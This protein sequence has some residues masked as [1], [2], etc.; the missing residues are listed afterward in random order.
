ML[1]T[2]STKEATIRSL[3]AY[4]SVSPQTMARPAGLSRESKEKLKWLSTVV[5][6]TVIA[7]GLVYRYA[8]I[9]QIN[10]Q[11]QQLKLQV[12]QQQD[13]IAKLS[14]TKQNLESPARILQI[15]QNK[16]GMV[17]LDT[18]S[19]SQGNQGGE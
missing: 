10:L 15:A 13:E 14:K 6:C 16:L 11:V 1:A 19:D 3:S 2:K 17:L 7:V 5:F 8:Q 9:A 18:P 12:Q 4:S